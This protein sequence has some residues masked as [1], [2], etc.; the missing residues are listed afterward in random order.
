MGAIA[1]ASGR[2]GFTNQILRRP[3][4]VIFCISPWN[5]PIFMPMHKICPALAFGN[6]VVMKP[7][8]FTPAANFL[9]TEISG[10]FFPDNLAQVAMVSGRAAS[11]AVSNG[12][13][14]GVSFTGLVPT[15]KLV[16]GAAARNL[17]PAQSELGGKNG[18]ILNDT[19]DL[20]GAVTQIMG[21]AFVTSGQRY[22]AISRVLVHKDL[23]TG[24]KDILTARANAMR[25]GP[26][27][28]ADSN[29][30]PLCNL[31]HWTDVCATTERAIGEGAK[32]L[33][34]W[35]NL[36]SS[37]DIPLVGGEN[38]YGIECFSSMA[39]V[40]LRILQPDVKN[41]VA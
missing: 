7:S 21:A 17:I 6:A 4:G 27:H 1:I 10:E 30:G 38:I 2:A 11:G 16:Y 23:A 40:G 26:G 36:A 28:E 5:F 18:A 22:T 8:Q 31:P 13:V 32:P 29:H 15:G 39:K 37:T 35:E 25:F 33:A 9:H 34:D 20:E 12:D 14:H 41:E 24:T 3:S 19:D